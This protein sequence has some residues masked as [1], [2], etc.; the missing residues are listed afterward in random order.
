MRLDRLALGLAAC[1]ALAACQS[2]DAT[3]IAP[4]VIPVVST[5]VTLDAG[6]IAAVKTG[7]KLSLQ[8]PTTAKFNAPFVATSDPAGK[9]NVCGLVAARK[10]P[11]GAG[12]KPFMG[13][14]LGAKFVT[15]E[16]GGIDSDTQ[17]ARAA[18]AEKGITI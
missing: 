14:F 17:I 5:P 12:D 10:I 9:I 13:H 1:A 3:Q 2:I 18:C 7:V 6:Q 16:L 8:N 4:T 11:G 15:D